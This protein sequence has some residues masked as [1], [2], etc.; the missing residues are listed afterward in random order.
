MT[1][2]KKGLTKIAK[3]LY[4]KSL[5]GNNVDEKKVTLI[6]KELTLA[7][8]AGTT[9]ILKIYKRLISEKL[10]FEELIIETNANMT[11]PKNYTNE[12]MEKTKAA[13]IINKVNPKIVFGARVVHG[14]WIWDETLENK[15][16]QI[17]KSTS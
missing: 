4:K 2:N 14:D 6:L 15:L 16:E 17:T 7:K 12:L 11:L 9:S 13:R 3:Y 1:Q 5:T 8:P 10:S